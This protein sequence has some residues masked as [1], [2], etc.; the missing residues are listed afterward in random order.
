MNTFEGI[1][2][3]QAEALVDVLR[4]QRERRCR[5]IV[6]DAE[7]RANQLAQ[8]SRRSAR[9][10]MREAVDEERRRRQRALI[11][12]RR[13]VETAGRRRIQARY[14]ELLGRAWPL[15]VRELERRWSTPADRAAWCELLV[16][17]AAAL[18]GTEGWTIVHPQPATGAWSE[19]DSDKLGG[20][21]AS[22][23]VKAADYRTDSE[24]RAGLQIRQ[25]G[26]RLDGS[27]DGLLAQRSDIEGRLLACWETE[28][29]RLGERNDG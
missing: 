3:R 14:D 8:D 7:R 17:E 27:I 20:M 29:R 12:A 28:V 1:V 4:E 19:E 10:R 25:G 6:A 11:E 5:E 15:L 23:G 2:G 24:L 18:F 21:L 22:F 26:A 16:D 9:E 13:R